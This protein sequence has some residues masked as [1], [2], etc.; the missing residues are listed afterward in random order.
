MDSSKRKT[1]FDSG[2]QT[3]IGQKE[4]EIRGLYLSDNI[5]WVIGYSGGKD[6]TAV[7]QLVWNAISKVPEERRTKPV[8]VISTDTLVENPIVSLW[9]TKSLKAMEKARLEQGFSNLRPHRLTPELQDRYWVNLIG[10]G[11]PAPRPKFRWCTSRLKINPSNNFIKNVVKQYGEA[12]LVLGTRKAESATR[13][14]NMSKYEATSTREKLSTHGQLDRS[15]VYTPIADWTNDDVWVYL[16]Q[17]RNP[18]G[19]RNEDLLG[20]YQGATEDGECPLVVDTSSPSCGDSRFG[21]FVCTL[22]DKDRSMQAMVQNDAEK[23]WMLPLMD[24]RNNY[25]DVRVDREHRDFRKMHGGL[26]FFNDRLV[27]GPYRK[28]YREKL[29][30]ELLE[31]Q[32]AVDELKPNEISDYS[33]ITFEELEEIRRIWVTEKH[34]IEDS[35]PRIYEEVTGKAYPGKPIQERQQ[36][37]LE[38]L[39][40]LRLCCEEADDEEGI[41]FQALTEML[42]IEHRYKTMARRSGLYGD[43]NKALEKSAFLT[44]KEAEE[45][46]RRR[47][48]SLEAVEAKG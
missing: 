11:Y 18:W 13:S 35:L 40:I 30:R 12:I 26:Q 6:S 43:L 42:S 34:E 22:V 44:E 8:H 9:V 38:D 47:S 24:F 25:L 5:P 41:L 4:E 37:S 14:A 10:K 15:W 36:L 3:T 33:L 29:L 31:A 20:M 27:H 2:F 23:E 7:L 28:D 19:H 45:F 39:E 46:A 16:T 1:A 17:T 21:C 32:I 48:Q